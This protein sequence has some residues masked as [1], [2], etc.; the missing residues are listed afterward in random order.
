MRFQDMPSLLL[1]L[2]I[3]NLKSLLTSKAQ[4]VNYQTNK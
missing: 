1:Q 2:L 4:L 3:C